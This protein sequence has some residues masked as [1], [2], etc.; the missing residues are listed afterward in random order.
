MTDAEPSAGQIQAA[1]DELLGWQGISRSPQLSQLLRYVVE[2]TLGGDTSSI[3]AYAIA[4]DVFGRPPTFDPQSDP[5]VRVQARRLRTL[6]EQY[7]EL[8][9]GESEVQIHLPLGRYVPEFSLVRRPIHGAPPPA[10]P[11]P[12]AEVAAPA[13]PPAA[14]AAV[15]AVPAGP[16]PRSRTRNFVLTAVL[17][18][19]FT[20]IGVALAV[21]IVRWTLP[22]VQPAAPAIP[23]IPVVSLGSF[24]N[25]TGN[26][27]LDKDVVDLASAIGNDLA[28]FE[29]VK[30]SKD[31]SALVLTATVQGTAAQPIMRATLT[32]GQTGG[33]V[34]STMLQS[35][36]GATDGAA[37]RE[38]APML[39][40]QLTGARGP[41]FAAGR[42]WLAQQTAPTA[43]PNE[44]VCRLAFDSW[45]ETRNEGQA[46]DAIG[47]FQKLMDRNPN[48]PLAMA[49][50]A[51]VASWRVQMN[52]RPGDQLV[53]LLVDEKAA[54][55]LAVKLMPNSSFVREQQS[56]VL[57]RQ[58]SLDDAE[59]AIA[60]AVNL[61][62]NSLDAISI[63]G[64]YLA[65]QGD[66]AHGVP[67]AQ[68]ALDGAPSPPPFYYYTT[69][70]NAL[71]E[72]RYFDAVDLGQSLAA[73]DGEAGQVI[74]LAAAPSAGRTDLID[75]YRP[76]ILGNPN[77]QQAGIIPRLSIYFRQDVLIRRVTEGLV[78]AGLP[79]NTLTA[80]F[81]PDGTPRI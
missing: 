20:L 77:F 60:A 23:D 2:K 24:D 79:P 48:D 36:S 70:L 40:R 8:G 21:M 44:Y 30:V 64:L 46:L 51:S 35:P 1:L 9:K 10:D 69:A 78:L 39:V 74:V 73:G 56:L 31:A 47:C 53:A 65:L 18:L 66:W 81:R 29:Y 71:R 62:P 11:P 41:L 68:E 42:A 6:L 72:H 63:K 75:R 16:A 22:G 15:A 76:A 52:A 3:K 45:R 43:T 59:A 13:V 49:G 17:G 38:L 67:L 5:I 14:A 55:D 80:P 58:G 32:S 4:V 33:I 12:P 50:S 27:A 7:Y 26:A 25:L 37:L 54:A 19:C 61:N 34:W 57:A 28:P